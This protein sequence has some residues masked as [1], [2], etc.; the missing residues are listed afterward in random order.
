MQNTETR[1]RLIHDASH[2][3]KWLNSSTS[4]REQIRESRRDAHSRGRGSALET[5]RPVLAVANE[6][7]RGLI[8][9]LVEVTLDYVR[10]WEKQKRKSEDVRFRTYDEY[11]GNMEPLLYAIEK[12]YRTQP[13]IAD[14]TMVTGR[15]TVVYE[16]ISWTRRVFPWADLEFAKSRVLTERREQFSRLARDGAFAAFHRCALPTCGNYFHAL[17]PE[18]RYCSKGC[19]R[20]QYVEHPLRAKK[21][22]AD[23]KVYYYTHK[24]LELAKIKDVNAANQR[25]YDLARKAEQSAKREQ[26]ALKSAMHATA[27]GR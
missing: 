12:R 6:F 21:T 5:F 2:F 23:Q 24:V 7:A 17:R 15:P 10:K 20:K 4:D 16:P 26:K 8:R 3:A 11:V 22:A 27:K 1:T 18:R 25:K 13:T 14:E 19:Q 9:P